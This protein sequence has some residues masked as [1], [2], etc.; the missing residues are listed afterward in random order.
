MVPSPTTDGTVALPLDA[1]FPTRKAE[2]TMSAAA[3]SFARSCLRRYGFAAEHPVIPEDS[4]IAIQ[5]REMKDALF[6][7][8]EQARRHG[9]HRPSGKAPQ[10][11][12]GDMRP[13][14][15]SVEKNRRELRAMLPVLNGWH[16]A[17][18]A[19][20]AGRDVRP[21]KTY[22]GRKIPKYGCFGEADTRLSTGLD[23]PVP[24][25]SPGG[26]QDAFNFVQRL[27]AHA[28]AAVAE[29]PRVVAVTKRWAK[30]YR[31]ATGLSRANPYTA[32]RDPRWQRTSEPSTKEIHAAVAHT[33]CQLR[34]NFLGVVDALT[35]RYEKRAEA[36]H[37]SR[38]R[39][40]RDFHR[41][42]TRKAE[43]VTHGRSG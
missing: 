20:E 40:V 6:V 8:E 29:E 7:P 16:R 3:D 14:A 39:A 1:Y 17:Q 33:R 21:Q 18:E 22:H 2:N 4:G 24:G 37:R 9:F 23:Q 30:C 15:E 25:S 13:D 5:L 26:A 19:R 11:A 28:A 35:V 43:Q 31:K 34:V 10:H 36:R 42:R 12:K 41:A 32:A 27:R 38:L